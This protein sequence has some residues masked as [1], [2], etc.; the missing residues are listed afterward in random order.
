[1]EREI[2]RG[3]EQD[4]EEWRRHKEEHD[5]HKGDKHREPK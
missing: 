1:M 3:D 4:A 2:E 5:E